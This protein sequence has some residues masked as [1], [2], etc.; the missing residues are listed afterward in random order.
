MINGDECEAERSLPFQKRGD[1]IIHG[2]TV[3][4]RE[5]LIEKD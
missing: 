5:G 2:G 1:E 3:D 4:S